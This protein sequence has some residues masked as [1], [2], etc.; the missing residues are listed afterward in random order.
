MT[1][2]LTVNQTSA[3]SFNKTI[4]GNESFF[5]NGANRNVSGPYLDTLVN[6]KGCDSFLTLNLTVNPTSAGSFNKTIC[7]NQSYFFNGANRNVSG[8]YIDTLVNAKG[9]DSFLTLNLTV[10]NFF[11]TSFN[12]TICSNQSYLWNGISRT[13]PG[14]YL[15]TFTSVSGCDSIVTLNLIVHPTSS[16]SFN[17]TICANQTY[18]FNGFNRNI[19]GAYIDTFS[20]SKGCDSIVTLNLTVTPLPNKT[21]TVLNNTITAVL[22]GANYQWYNCLTNIGITGANNQS[23]TAT[24]SGSYKVAISQNGCSDTSI[25]APISISG[26]HNY[27]THIIEVYPNPSQGSFVLISSESGKYALVNGLGQELRIFD[28]TIEN[29]NSIDVSDI[30][31]G[32]YYI[33][34]MGEQSSIGNKIVVVAK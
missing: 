28:L 32:I 4:C 27:S 16:H 34:K 23:Y 21:I 14:A 19:S 1:L 22:A 24:T 31:S 6:A 20:N 15:D 10:T 5:F 11:N 26:I 2:N 29:K 3:G 33:K 8:P 18:F 17:Q 12:Q 30:E 13:I 9:C 25:C 7:S